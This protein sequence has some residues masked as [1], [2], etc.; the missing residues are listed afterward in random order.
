MDDKYRSRRWRLASG[1]I[2]SSTVALFGGLVGMLLGK[3]MNGLAALLGAYS[4][5]G[6]MVL[7]AYGYSR[8]RWG[9]ADD[10]PGQKPRR[11]AASK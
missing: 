3:D 10:M 2:I 9:A 4:A 5:T 11:Y 6:G 8:S 7:G 1:I